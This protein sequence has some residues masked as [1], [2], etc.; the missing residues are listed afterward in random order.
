VGNLTYLVYLT[1]FV[2]HAE[3]FQADYQREFGEALKPSPDSPTAVHELLRRLAANDVV[4]M[5]NTDNTADAVGVPNQGGP[6]LLA[7][8]VSSKFRNNKTRDWKLSPIAMLPAISSE[9]VTNLYI[10][11]E[12]PHPNAAKLLLRWMS[13]EVDG[14]SEGFAPFNTIG[15]WS[16]RDDI[17]PEAGSVPLDSI[18]I[19]TNDPAYLYANVQDMRDFWLS[20]PFQTAP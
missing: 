16:F 3:D 14:K 13:G 10:V 7:W 19:Y 9:S 15:G 8:T 20:L 4:I 17:L 6:G 12:A 2:Q 5:A 18:K 11:N 1:S